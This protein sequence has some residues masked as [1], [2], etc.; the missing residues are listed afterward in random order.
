MDERRSRKLYALMKHSLIGSA[1]AAR[2]AR[3]DDELFKGE[4][5]TWVNQVPL[6][7]CRN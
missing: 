7:A 1:D 3:K 4:S 5:I 2:E 6:A